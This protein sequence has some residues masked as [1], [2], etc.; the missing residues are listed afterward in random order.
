MLNPSLNY[1]LSI[2]ASLKG[3]A[4]SDCAQGESELYYR[5]YQCVCSSVCL[6]VCK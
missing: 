2:V 4:I 5:T 6:Y 1:S 3:E